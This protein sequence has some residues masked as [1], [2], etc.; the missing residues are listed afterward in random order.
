MVKQI[1]IQEQ[2][3][4]MCHSGKAE[5][6]RQ[7]DEEVWNLCEKCN[8]IIE[9]EYWD[10]YWDAKAEQHCWEDFDEN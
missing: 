5:H 2:V 1:S 7:I 6:K 4:Q 8:Y 3:C 9:Q 10:A